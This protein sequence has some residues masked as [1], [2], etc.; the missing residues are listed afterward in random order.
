MDTYQY[1]IDT[2]RYRY[3][4]TDTYGYLWYDRP[5]GGRRGGGGGTAGG[6]TAGRRLGGERV[7]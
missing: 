7:R 6:G 3:I 5:C 1:N 2:Y 4:H